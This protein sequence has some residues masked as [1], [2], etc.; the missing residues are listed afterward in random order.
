M[1]GKEADG[2]AITT[3]KRVEK[4]FRVTRE[5]Y[6]RLLPVIEQ[7]MSHDIYCHDGQSYNLVN[8]YFDDEENNVIIN[9]IMKPQ[10]KEKLRLRCYGPPAS[11]DTIVYFEIKSK[12]YGT[13]IKRRAGMTYKDAMEYI[14]TGKRPQTDIYIYRQVMDEID[15]LRKRMPCEPKVII[16]YDRH[17]YFWREDPHVRLTFDENILSSRTVTDPGKYT[18]G[19]PL[20]GRDEMLLEIKTPASIPLRLSQILSEENIF[21]TSFSKYG[22]EFRTKKKAGLL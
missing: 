19:D 3:F 15:E 5:Q 4:K 21:I 12:L 13:V 14:R 6:T 7:Y 9:S 20:I 16:S 2:V 1:M 11:D 18:G 22:Y 8:L 10:Y 17:A